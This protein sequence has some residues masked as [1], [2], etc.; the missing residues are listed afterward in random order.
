MRVWPISRVVG[1]LGR[2]AFGR[3]APVSA[4][5]PTT[6]TRVPAHD[7]GDRAWHLTLRIESGRPVCLNV[8]GSFSSDE[9]AHACA[10]ALTRAA[11]IL[12]GAP[13]DGRGWSNAER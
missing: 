9:Q 11:H 12:K 7:A 3:S 2:V 1:W 13:D 5:R 6:Y 8:V 4:D 10:T